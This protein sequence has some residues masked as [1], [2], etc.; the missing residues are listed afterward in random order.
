LRLLPVKD[1]TSAEVFRNLL[2]QSGKIQT[3]TASVFFD[4]TTSGDKSGELTQYR[5]TAGKIM[6]ER[7]DHMRI[8][9]QVEVIL[10]NL[11]IMVA[12]GKTYKVWIP[13]RNQYGEADVNAPLA[14]KKSL[15][16]LRPKIFLDGLFVDIRPYL[17]KNPNMRY[18]PE[19]AVVGTHRYYVYTFF[20]ITSEAPEAR[21]LEKIWVDRTD[22]QIWRKQLF[23]KDGSIETDVE[24]E[25]YQPVSGVSMPQ[26]ITIQRPMEE[27]KVKM[28]LQMGS[29]KLNEKLDPALWDLPRPEGAQLLE[30]TQA[31]K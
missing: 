16:N 13:L 12:D 1:A 30:L 5:Q 17:N 6:V 19:E 9:V 22:L 23:G 14:A 3:L 27:F 18:F 8:H 2:E 11:A 24:Y 4:T 29:V 26:A 10:T 7:P 31:G 28:T 20:D 25:N 21:V 15:L